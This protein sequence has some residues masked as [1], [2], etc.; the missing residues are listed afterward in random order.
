LQNAH[1][2]LKEY[3]LVLQ[4]YHLLLKLGF[5]GSRHGFLPNTNIT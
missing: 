2:L 3:I 4:V 5:G 1:L